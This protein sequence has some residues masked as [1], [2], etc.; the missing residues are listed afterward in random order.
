MRHDC[1]VRTLFAAITLTAIVTA[2][3]AN[4]FCA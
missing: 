1:C 3:A 2:G 4:T